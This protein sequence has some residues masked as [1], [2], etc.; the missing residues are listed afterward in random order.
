MSINSLIIVGVIIY[1]ISASITFIIMWRSEIKYAGEVG[2][3]TLI[4]IITICLVAWHL[5][6]LSILLIWLDKK[7]K[8]YQRK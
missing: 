1:V 4:M 5:G 3:G 7:V 2:L 8:I 6:A